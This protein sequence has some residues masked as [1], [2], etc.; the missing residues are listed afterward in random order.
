VDAPQQ[1]PGGPGGRE[2]ASNRSA[3]VTAMLDTPSTTKERLPALDLLRFVAA[4]MVLL[5]HYTFRGA[6]DPTFVTTTFPELDGITR[7]GS[8]GVYLF[9]II[10]GFVILLTVDAGGRRPAHFVASRISRLYPAFWAAVIVTFIV[11][12]LAGATFAVGIG[13]YFR[14][15]GMFPSWIRAPYVDGVYWTLELE[16]TFYLLMVGYLLFF[17]HR[18]R[19]EWLLLGWLLVILPFAPN[20]LGPGRLRVGLMVSA[21]PYFIGG[22]IFYLAWRSGWTRLRVGLLAGSWLVACVEAMRVAQS[23]QTEFATP[24]SPIVAAAVASI[25][26]IVFLGLVLRPAWFRF[27]GRRATMLGALTYPLY[28]V[29]QFIGYVVINVIA[30]VAGRWVAVMAATATVLAIAVAIHRLVERRYNGRLRRWLEPRLTAFDRVAA[31][32]G[33]QARGPFRALR[34]AEPREEP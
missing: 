25:G 11:C 9:F 1:D 34:R 21:A 17:Q 32:G 15:L 3:A 14:N 29:H 31:R 5:F 8:F 20:E 4:A 27:G 28:L 2:I 12:L 6:V 26:F 23:A 10:S 16:L 22:C 7:Y 24:F 30:P 19:I 33:F 13:D 18:F